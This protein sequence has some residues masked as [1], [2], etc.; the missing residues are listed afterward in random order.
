MGRSRK[1]ASGEKPAPPRMPPPKNP[2]ND[3][4]YYISC[5]DNEE[6]AL[7]DKDATWLSDFQGQCFECMT[8]KAELLIRELLVQSEPALLESTTLAPQLR[9][10]VCL[11]RAYIG[12]DVDGLSFIGPV[13]TIAGAQELFAEW[14][15]YAL[16]R[17]DFA[18]LIVTFK[19]WIRRCKCIAATGGFTEDAMQLILFYMLA[20][21]AEDASDGASDGACERC[22]L[23]GIV[24]SYH[25]QLMQ[26]EQ[27]EESMK[28]DKVETAHRKLH[29]VVCQ[30]LD[31]ISE[32]QNLQC[33]YKLHL[34][35][36]WNIAK[37]TPCM[38]FDVGAVIEDDN[39]NGDGN[40]DVSDVNPS[41]FSSTFT[42]PPVAAS[43]V[44]PPAVAAVAAPYD[45]GVHQ[46]I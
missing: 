30:R 36:R 44:A 10:L 41:T 39:N 26:A 12:V 5:S 33:A 24:T 19:N 32:G 43:A 9:Y 6:D 13:V 11:F 2:Y 35:E 15:T 8:H 27:A 14:P 31:A 4:G 38:H 7:N 42:D 40:V 28:K 1:R 45:V 34:Q 20:E 29:E 22:G 18:D 16:P 46:M 25:G 17:G 3:V 23:D 37:R 21:F